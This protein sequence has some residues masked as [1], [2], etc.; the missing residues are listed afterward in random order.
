MVLKAPFCSEGWCFSRLGA[1]PKGAQR[2]T[3]PWGCATDCVTRKGQEGGEE[4]G[5]REGETSH[6]TSPG[7]LLTW[8][9]SGRETGGCGGETVFGS[10]QQL[11]LWGRR[12]AATVAYCSQHHLITWWTCRAT[13][14]GGCSD[15]RQLPLQALQVPQ[16]EGHLPVLLSF[17]PSVPLPHCSSTAILPRCKAPANP[18][19]ERCTT[20]GNPASRRPCAGVLCT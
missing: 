16:L 7:S 20:R 18:I 5:Q 15:Q 13:W 17:C 11:D 4:R 3:V 6:E 19:P 14:V 9:T 1:I 2:A 8:G 10:R 12:G